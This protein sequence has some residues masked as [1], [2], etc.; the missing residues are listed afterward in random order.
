MKPDVICHS[1]KIGKGH[2]NCKDIFVQQAP[3]S[4]TCVFAIGL[5]VTSF[6]T[7]RF[8]NYFFC[9]RY[10][11]R[12][13][14]KLFDK[15]L[16]ARHCVVLKCCTKITVSKVCLFQFAVL[17]AKGCN[18]KNATFQERNFCF[19]KLHHLQF[20]YLSVLY[21]TLKSSK[22][23]VP[24]YC[25]LVQHINCAEAEGCTLNITNK[26]STTFCLDTVD[27]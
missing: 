26:G 11:D 5:L 7:P 13:K 14:M 21:F 10:L 9:N 8:I 24:I 16:V 15:N 20:I 1:I 17:E 4:W 27:M 2:P 3:T 23:R 12:P 25:V 19:W 22:D 18:W 6:R